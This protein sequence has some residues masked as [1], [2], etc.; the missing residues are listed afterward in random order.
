MSVC[1]SDLISDYALDFIGLQESMKKD[2][3]RSFFRYI[4]PSG[5]FFW[6]WIPFVGKSGGILC[7]AR[8]DTLEVYTVKFG[9][10]MILMNL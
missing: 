9:N 6:K 2:Y 8:S 5:C 10:F 7:G 3:K 4:D 1:L